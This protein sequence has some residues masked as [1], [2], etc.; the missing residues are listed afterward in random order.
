MR[1][2]LL[3]ILLVVTIAGFALVDRYS[4]AEPPLPVA[5]TPAHPGGVWACPIVKMEGFAG[6]IHLLNSGPDS[7]IVRITYVPDGRKPIERAITVGAGRTTTIGTPGSI[8]PVAAGA[9]LQYAGGS[10]TASRTALFGGAAGAAACT[11]PGAATVFVPQ[12]STLKAETELAILNPTADDAVVDIALLQN[13]EPLRPQLLTGRV[14]PAGSRLVLREGDFA[15]D[16][17]TVGAE[18]TSST[19]RVA[20]DGAL[21]APATVDIVPGAPA[22]REVATVANNARGEAWFSVVAVGQDDAVTTS[23]VL[24]SQG[25]TT[26]GPLV[27]GLAPERPLFTK[28]ASTTRG[29]LAL[30]VLS[31]TSPVAIGA[32]WQIVTAGGAADWAVSSGVVPSRDV[33]AVVG[34]PATPAATRL[35]VTNPDPKEA[36]VGVTVFTERGPSRPTQ[37]QGVHIAPGRTIALSFSGLAQNATVGVDVRSTGGAVVAVLESTTTRPVFGAYAITAAP[38][39][40][41]LPVAVVP[42]ARQ[43]VPAP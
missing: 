21:V 12:G 28:A 36:I 18:I 25:P 35:L 15:F 11:R 40:S 13:G 33:L 41:S 42:D 24:T 32:R 17:R 34:S 4:S 9:I 30:H 10:I 26:F 19:G 5:D 29:P 38:V 23:R 31:A 3:G 16:L 7:S 43:G 39:I 27:T 6:Y 22:G 8:L 1:R 2:S 14:I 20:V 37:L